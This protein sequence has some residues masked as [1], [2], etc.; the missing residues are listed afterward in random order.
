MTMKTDLWLLA[1]IFFGAAEAAVSSNYTE[2]ILSSGTSTHPSKHIGYLL[3]M[4]CSQAR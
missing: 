4:Y 2:A 3:T 1:A